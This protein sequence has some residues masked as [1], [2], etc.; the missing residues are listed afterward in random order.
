MDEF[1]TVA[2]LDLGSFS[3]KVVI[4]RLLGDGEI[5]II[6]TG[7]Y[8]SSGIKNGTIINIETTSK[9]IIEAISDAELMAGQEI[10]SV[11]AS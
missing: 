4:G 11:V 3:T 5:E 10:D 9:G 6:G 1:H 2:S 7:I 8:P